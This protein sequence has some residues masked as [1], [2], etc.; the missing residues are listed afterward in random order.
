MGLV[1]VV[2]GIVHETRTNF[3]LSAVLFTQCRVSV[4]QVTCVFLLNTHVVFLLS[5]KLPL[6]QLATALAATVYV[7]RLHYVT[8]DADGQ[9]VGSSVETVAGPSATEATQATQTEV[10]TQETQPIQTQ[11]AQLTQTPATQ[12]TQETQATQ[13]ATPATTQTPTPAT[14]QTPTATPNDFALAILA[15]HNAKRALHSAPPLSWS[16]ELA[17]YAQ[18]AANNYQCGSALQHTGGPYGENLAEGYALGPA[19]VD[20]WYSEGNLYNYNS[21]ELNHFTQIV[22]KL[23][24]QL[25]CASK[26]CGLGLYVVCEYNPPGNFVGQNAANVLA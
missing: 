26:L 6:L 3:V 13:P 1:N 8:V 11:L 23:L 4:P 16:S 18:N 9:L 17:Q 7:T 21:G 5:M 15:A 24:T 2:G 19:A 22:W 12:E 20:G 14:T 10:E 25:G